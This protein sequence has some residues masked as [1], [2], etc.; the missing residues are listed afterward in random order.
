[1]SAWLSEIKIHGYRLDN[2]PRPHFYYSF[3]SAQADA[4]YFDLSSIF[5]L[6]P[7]FILFYFF[8]KFGAFGLSGGFVI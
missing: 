2:L 3:F 5:D 4:V 6:V 1:L 7:H 8:H